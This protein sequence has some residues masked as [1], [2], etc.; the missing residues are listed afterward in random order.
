MLFYRDLARRLGSDQPF[1]GLQIRTVNGVQMPHASL[2]EMAAH[3]LGEVRR[4]QPEGPYYMGGSSF[5]GAVAFEMAQQLRAQ[6]ETAALVALLDT[7]APGHPRLLPDVTLRRH[8]FN[9]LKQRVELHAETLRML[10]PK[11]RRDYLVRRAGKLPKMIKQGIKNKYRKIAPKFYRAVGH[12]LPESLQKSH[13]AILDA[14]LKY[15]PQPYAGRV[16]LFRAKTQLQGV[17]PEPMMGWDELVTGELEI[18]EVPGYHGTIVVE[19]RV[20]F[21]A[22]KLSDALAE[23]QEVESGKRA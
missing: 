1:Y 10:D 22:E 9:H 19:P 4:L 8:K 23:A 21:L 6:G 18:L 3:Y 7:Y 16:T 15:V 5:G 14:Y 11:G 2:E 17:Y 20:R 12:T 13:N